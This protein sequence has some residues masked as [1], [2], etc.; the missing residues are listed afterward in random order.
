MV[1]RYFGPIISL[2]AIGCIF[3]FNAYFIC[4]GMYDEGQ[5]SKPV[6]IGYLMLSEILLN[7]LLFH[8]Y[9]KHNRVSSLLTQKNGTISGSRCRHTSQQVQ[10]MHY[11]GSNPYQNDVSRRPAVTLNLETNDFAKESHIKF[12]STCNI[13]VPMRSHHCTM[14]NYC[15]LRK[16]HHCYFMGGCVGF[17]NQRYFIVFLFWSVIGS[18]YATSFTFRYLNAYYMPFWPFG[19]I[20]YIF[21]VAA[22]NFLYTQQG[23]PFQLLVV[24][25]FSVGSA[26]GVSSLMFL[27][28]QAYLIGKGRTMIEQQNIKRYEMEGKAGI[29]KCYAS[30]S[31]QN[32][33]A[34]V[35]GPYWCL[36]FI[37]PLPCRNKYDHGF[38]NW[39]YERYLREF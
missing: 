26:S 15:V 27:V 25:L 35:F 23:D 19:W 13:D 22:K 9:K 31:L 12:C 34:T 29:F 32:K 21:P 33:I 17:G 36:N 14:C 16:D 11:L 6:R 3:Y 38:K 28:Y 24:L 18:I 7:F 1:F 5:C 30:T 37:L 2:T 20:N 39:L 4:P 10:N 8:Y